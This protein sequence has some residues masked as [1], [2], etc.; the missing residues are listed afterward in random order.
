VA[1]W[2]R[3][4]SVILSFLRYL[5]GTPSDESGSA[6]AHCSVPHCSPHP[7]RLRYG[8]YQALLPRSSRSIVWSVVRGYGHL[9]LHLSKLRGDI[10]MLHQCAREHLL[11]VGNVVGLWLVRAIPEHWPQLVWKIL[12]RRQLCYKHWRYWKSYPWSLLYVVAPTFF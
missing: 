8:F 7:S 6:R 5:N 3:N 12:W 4:G 1:D 10:R 11:Y 2:R 9:R